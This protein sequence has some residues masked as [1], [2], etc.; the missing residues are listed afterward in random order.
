[1]PRFSVIVPAYKLQAHLHACLESVL[2]QTYESDESPAFDL[3]VIAVDAGSPDSCGEIID[4]VAARDPR[5]VAVHLPADPADPGQGPGPARNAGLARATGEYVLFLDGDDTLAPHALRDIAD[6]LK[7]SG[8]PDVLV[9][10]HAHTHWSGER[11]YVL[12]PHLTESGPVSFP[13]DERP[14]LLRQPSPSWNKAYKREFTEREGLTFAPGRHTDTFWSYATLLAAG[15]LSTL[16]RVCVHHRRRRGAAATSGRYFDLFPQYDRTFDFIDSR[17]ELNRWRPVLARRMAEHL[18]AA[19]ATVLTAPGLSARTRT[20]FF[21]LARAHYGRHRVPGAAGLRYAGVRFGT[22][23]IYRVLRGIRALRARTRALAAKVVRPVRSAALGLHYRVQRCRPVREDL[24]VFSAYGNRGYACN[25]AAIE[26]KVRELVPGMRTAWITAPEQDAT[27]PSATP[28]LRPESFGYFEAL[29]RAKYLVSNVEFD[30]RLV[31]RR[32]QI[33]LQTHHGTPLKT[34]GLDL[35]DRPAAS[36]DTD[37]A[38]LLADA[39]KWDYA[40]SAN[41]HATLVGERAFPASY[42]TLEYGSPRNDVL[43]RATPAGVAALREL[44]GVPQQSTV[45]LYA[46]TYRDYSRSQHLPLD[47]ERL[48][49][50]LGPEFFLLTRAHFAYRAPLNRTPLP[51]VLDV[52]GYPSVEELFL[53]SDALVTDYSSLMF[54]FVTLDRPIVI[55]DDDREAYEAARGTYF[56]L[57][58]CPPGAVARNEDELID[59]FTTGHWRGSRSAQL[60]SAFRTRFCPY[61]DGHAAERVVRRVFLGDSGSAPA[62]TGR[63]LPAQRVRGAEFA[64]AGASR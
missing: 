44:L 30:H 20:E 40:L 27:V 51:R 1:M 25:P 18:V 26:A 43:H 57:R 3:E 22:Y 24:A 36:R 56:D 5:V 9:F 33:L 58:S 13:L 54:D 64:P 34:V 29:A 48:G 23:R 62:P 55:L 39:D 16:E 41:R 6:R 52:T 17:P 10:G 4:E 38:R 53:V 60:R 59:I 8:D 61:D 47:L 35:T 11:E 49:R 46:P 19:S 42:T 15:S 12:P 14:D 28:R 31:K 45:V 2:S 63:N 37:A 7:A 21:R 50:A 32:G